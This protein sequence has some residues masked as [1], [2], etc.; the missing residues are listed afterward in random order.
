MKVTKKIFLKSVLSI[1]SIN[2]TQFINILSLKPKKS[3]FLPIFAL[4]QLRI[5]PQRALQG[6]PKGFLPHKDALPVQIYPFQPKN[7][8]D[9]RYFML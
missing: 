7:N 8:P 3:F 2:I 1:L 9:D 6:G 4:F 5:G